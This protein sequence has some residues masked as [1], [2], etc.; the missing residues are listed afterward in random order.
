MAHGRASK[1]PASGA[2]RSPIN[3][4]LQQRPAGGRRK[5]SEGNQRRFRANWHGILPVPRLDRPV[6]LA[7][8]VLGGFR[9]LGELQQVADLLSENDPDFAW[10][11]EEE[12]PAFVDA[13]DAAG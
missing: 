3:L 8:Q 9:C 12:L 13:I 10:G 5:W 7:L 2:V 11:R 1:K 4:G 6:F